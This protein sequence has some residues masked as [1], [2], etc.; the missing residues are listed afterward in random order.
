MTETIDKPVKAQIGVD[1]VFNSVTLVVPFS[2]HRQAN[3]CWA[4]NLG[5]TRLTTDEDTL[6]RLETSE[7]QPLDTFNLQL[8]D[9]SFRHFRSIS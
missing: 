6:Q 3:D 7:D 1:V 2:P 8:T 9:F 5:V 4:L